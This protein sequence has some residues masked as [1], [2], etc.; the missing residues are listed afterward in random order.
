MNS[1]NA[2][3][4]NGAA[5]GPDMQIEINRSTLSLGFSHPDPDT[6]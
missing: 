5:E 1:W 4:L 3:R 2:W 6:R